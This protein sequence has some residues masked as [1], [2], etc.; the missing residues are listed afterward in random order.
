MAVVEFLQH[1]WGSEA[2]EA[3]AASKAEQCVLD[4]VVEMMCGAKQVEPETLT[5]FGEERIAGS[6]QVSFRSIPL[7]FPGSEYA[8]YVESGAK[9]RNETGIFRRSF[10]TH[11]VIKMQDV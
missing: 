8:R 10:A 2:G 11:A 5:L 1:T 7:L 3:G 4:D 6:T 9:G